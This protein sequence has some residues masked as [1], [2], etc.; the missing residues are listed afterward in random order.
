MDRTSAQPQVNLSWLRSFPWNSSIWICLLGL[1][2]HLVRK[3]EEKSAKLL[4]MIFANVCEVSN[5]AYYEFR[6]CDALVSHCWMLLIVE[7]DST[8]SGQPIQCQ[9]SSKIMTPPPPLPVECVPPE[10]TLAGWRGGWRVNILEDARHSSVFQVCKY[11]MLL[12][13]PNRRDLFAMGQR[14][15]VLPPFPSSKRSE[16]R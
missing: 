12:I 15:R 10:D 11:F 16:G 1:G 7:R 8:V 14:H 6:S 5:A 13:I 9:A 2:Q 3:T 4:V